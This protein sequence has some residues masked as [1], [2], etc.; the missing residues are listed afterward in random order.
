MKKHHGHGGHSRWKSYGIVALIS[1]GV[2]LAATKIDKVRS[3]VF[4]PPSA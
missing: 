4:G 2:L 1:F 3:F